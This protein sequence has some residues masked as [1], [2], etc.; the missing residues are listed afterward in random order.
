MAVESS[1]VLGAS[2]CIPAMAEL[3]E[4]RDSFHVRVL[5][6]GLEILFLDCFIHLAFIY[7]SI[8]VVHAT[9]W[10]YQVEFYMGGLWPTVY[11]AVVG[12]PYR[13]LWRRSI[14]C[15]VESGEGGLDTLPDGAVFNRLQHLQGILFADGSNLFCLVQTYNYSSLG[16]SRGELVLCHFT[17][18]QVHCSLGVELKQSLN[19]AMA[20][21]V[22]PGPP[23]A[24]L[25]LFVF[26][27]HKILYLE[28]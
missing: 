11:K 18:R 25:Y 20:V 26:T 8:S 14:L 16:K 6:G 27:V 2:G 28:Q 12:G 5:A 24:L 9:L 15:A 7:R 17:S 1:K 22:F 23:T 4:G 10:R 3:S 19:A 13:V 21:F